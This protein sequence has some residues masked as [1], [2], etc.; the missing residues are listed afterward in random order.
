MH[1]GLLRHD[2]TLDRG[3]EDIAGLE[4][5][6]AP[7]E[8]V[9]ARVALLHDYESLWAQDAQP[10]SAGATYWKQL[11]LFYTAL[12]S[13]G[14]DVDVRHPDHDLSGAPRTVVP[15]QKH[16]VFQLDPVV[17]CLEDPDFAARQHQHH[18]ARV[19][20]VARFH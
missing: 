2:E 10:H 14:V 5:L 18:A 9:P 7:N 12:R 17:H 6:S 8:P 15:G 16:A 4:I 11:M 13:L 3:G 19:A 1:S 20:E